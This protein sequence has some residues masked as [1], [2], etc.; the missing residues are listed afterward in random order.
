MSLN[1]RMPALY[2]ALGLRENHVL[3]ELAPTELDGILYRVI[4]R[5]PNRR[6]HLR[7]QYQCPICTRWIP[8]GRAG[9]HRRRLDHQGV[10]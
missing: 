1:G 8:V 5:E 7:L 3:P 10:S 6:M 9:Q 4:A 2:R